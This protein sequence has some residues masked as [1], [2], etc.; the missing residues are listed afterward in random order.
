MHS[1]S[2]GLLSSWAFPW[3]NEHLPCTNNNCIFLCYQ[4]Y[5]PFPRNT[6]SC[7]NSYQTYL[8]S[9]LTLCKR[10]NT[11]KQKLHLI[12]VTAKSDDWSKRKE[13]IQKNATVEEDTHQGSEIKYIY[14]VNTNPTTPGARSLTIPRF[15]IEQNGI[16]KNS[17]ARTYNIDY[18][19]KSK[20]KLIASLL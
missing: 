9:L 18:F 4:K 20:W 10:E 5:S 16:K 1:T 19:M 17:Q 11:R 3:Q 2:A 7:G 15:G 12:G 8:V 13:T 6:F 14:F